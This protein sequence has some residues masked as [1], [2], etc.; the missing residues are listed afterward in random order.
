MNV[1]TMKTNLGGIV[2]KLGIATMMLVY[3]AV[4]SAQS[5]SR[6][7]VETPQQYEQQPHGS[8]SRPTGSTRQQAG[9]ATKSPHQDGSLIGMEGY[10]P[11]CIKDMKKWVRG[12]PEFQSIYKG[13]IYYFPAAK[14]KAIFDANP[15]KYAPVLNGDCAVALKKMKRRVP[16]NIRHAAIHQNQL[17]LFANEAAKQEFIANPAL[18]EVAAPAPEQGHDMGSGAKPQ[19]SSTKPQGS[20]TNQG[21]GHSGSSNRSSGSQSR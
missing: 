19:G 16:G 12:K 15:Q 10:C 14:Q 8:S 21:S 17:Y 3:P 9:S 6:S 7:A 11:V 4:V 13:K 20:G 2:F 5:G 1:S 18:Y